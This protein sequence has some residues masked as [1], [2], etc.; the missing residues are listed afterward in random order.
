[1]ATTKGINLGHWPEMQD[2]FVG[3]DGKPLEK[4]HKSLS[5]ARF[6]VI[7][8]MDWLMTND[9]TL[10]DSAPSPAGGQEKW[11]F[12][13]GPWSNFKGVPYEVCIDLA[14]K[15]KA[16]SW[17]NIPHMATDRLVNEIAWRCKQV[18]RPDQELIVE[19]SNECWNP[20][21]KQYQY[22]VDKSNQDAAPKWALPYMEYHVRRTRQVSKIFKKVIPNT[23]IVLATQ[24]Y[25]T[26]ASNQLFQFDL[27]GIDAIAIAPYIMRQAQHKV[28]K[29]WKDYE[30][31]LEED[32][33][34]RYIPTVDHWVTKCKEHGFPLYG[35]EFNYHVVGD[36]F[37]TAKNIVN[38]K[39]AAEYLNK[40]VRHWYKSGADVLCFYSFMSAQDGMPWGMLDAHTGLWTPR[41]ASFVWG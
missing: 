13:G 34:K 12:K 4:L 9:S 32:Y 38:S 14:N 23:T 30:S 3:K 7:R 37:D 5:K 20:I 11:G 27:S 10:V 1:M 26:A 40:C 18:L 2:V 25:N 19:Y 36:G 29:N 17:I 39:I 31:Y 33:C 8:H 35:Y 24:A 6:G 21:F 16:T 41:Y 15:Y 22:C 28:V